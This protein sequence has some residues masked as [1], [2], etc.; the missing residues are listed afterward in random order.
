MRDVGSARLSIL[1]PGVNLGN[2]ESE[3]KNDYAANVKCV[4]DGFLNVE[5]VPVLIVGW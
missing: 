5:H 4:H 2:C 1:I 3:N